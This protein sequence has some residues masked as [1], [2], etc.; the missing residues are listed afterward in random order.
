MAWSSKKLG[1]SKSLATKLENSENKTKNGDELQ[2]PT[3]IVEGTSLEVTTNKQVAT[4]L[5][6]LL[7]KIIILFW[8]HLVRF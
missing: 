8:M 2:E 4:T 6:I 5:Q 3:P 1:S 7:W